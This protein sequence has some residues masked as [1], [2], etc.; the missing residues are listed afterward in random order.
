VRLNNEKPIQGCKQPT[1]SCW[2]SLGASLLDTN[3]ERGT[4]PRAK[5][6]SSAVLPCTTAASAANP[7]PSLKRRAQ[8]LSACDRRG[9]W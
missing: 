4:V 3:S 7:G 6:L 5:A 8:S 2:A 9:K 1:L